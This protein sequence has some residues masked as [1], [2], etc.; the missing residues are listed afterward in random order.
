M[1]GEDTS[2][3]NVDV[4]TLTGRVIIAVGKRKIAR[5]LIGE[6]RRLADTLQAP[7]RVSPARCSACQLC[8]PAPDLLGSAYCVATM[9]TTP[10]SAM[11]STSGLARSALRASASKVP[12]EV[13]GADQR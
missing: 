11:D 10:S 6:V 2:V 4:D 5:V 3:D 13:R 1:V 12:E 9:V 8:R 7:G